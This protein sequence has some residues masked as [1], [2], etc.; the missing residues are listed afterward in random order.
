MTQPVMLSVRSIA[1][2]VVPANLL[3]GIFPGIAAPRINKHAAG[4]LR[5]AEMNSRQ[6]QHLYEQGTSEDHTSEEF[7]QCPQCETRHCLARKGN[8]R[9]LGRPRPRHLTV[10]ILPWAQ[11]SLHEAAKAA[12]LIVRKDPAGFDDISSEATAKGKTA[13]EDVRRK[14][15]GRSRVTVVRCPRG[16]VFHWSGRSVICASLP[17]MSIPKIRGTLNRGVEHRASMRDD[18][19]SHDSPP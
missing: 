10:W 7:R 15:A 14:Q 9:M 17:A 18:L 5:A 6:L 19:A 12:V 11:A 13:T 8:L 2:P 3:A 1:W 16:G 4:S